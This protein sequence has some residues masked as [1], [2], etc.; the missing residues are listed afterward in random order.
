MAHQEQAKCKDVRP[1]DRVPA[2][3]GM[4]VTGLNLTLPP[5]GDEVNEP[6]VPFMVAAAYFTSRALHRMRAK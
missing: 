6:L 4:W 3:P 1:V 5:L 2:E